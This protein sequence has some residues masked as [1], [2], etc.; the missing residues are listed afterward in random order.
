MELL[1]SIFAI[2]AIRGESVQ[3]RAPFE[4]KF[5]LVYVHIWVL[6]SPFNYFYLYTYIFLFPLEA[7]T[8]ES[9]ILRGGEMESW[10][11]S[12]YKGE[13]PFI[14]RLLR[15][16]SLKT[17]LVH[18]YP[19]Q[20][21][22]QSRTARDVSKLSLVTGRSRVPILLFKSLRGE[23]AIAEKF[24][25]YKQIKSGNCSVVTQWFHSLICTVILHYPLIVTYTFRSP[26]M[27]DKYRIHWKLCNSPRRPPAWAKK[28]FSACSCCHLLV[29]KLWAIPSSP[30]LSF[31]FTVEKKKVCGKQWE[32]RL[33]EKAAI[34]WPVTPRGGHTISFK[35]R[36]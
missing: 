3:T 20:K 34:M 30:K 2:T 11:P 28:A 31:I 10:W 22:L 6:Y 19:L 26:N 33:A 9:I 18:L 13:M 5:L 36:E 27:K 12:Q 15:L 17:V 35:H 21:V 14:C 16:F 1:H 24:G 29:P 8:S 23:L 4:N 7:S 32:R 25:Q